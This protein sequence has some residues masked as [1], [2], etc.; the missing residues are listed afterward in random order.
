MLNT[1]VG[2]FGVFLA[3]VWL[4]AILAVFYHL[5]CPR[6]KLKAIFDAVYVLLNGA[7]FIIFMHIYNLGNFRFFLV[8]GLVVGIFIEKFFIAKTLAQVKNLLYNYLENKTKKL[9]D[10]Y[11]SKKIAKQ[12]AK[13]NKPNEI[14]SKQKKKFFKIF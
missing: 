3:F 11:K 12:S 5:F 1:T 10:C 6:K 13:Q 7:M 14:K 2:Q 9:V 4:G 8:L